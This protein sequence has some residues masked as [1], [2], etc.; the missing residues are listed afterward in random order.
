MSSEPAEPQLLY[1]EAGASWY[2]L[3]AGPAAAISI[4]LVQA[5]SGAH[6]SYAVPL[7]FLV[8]VSFFLGIQVKA[9]RVHTSLELTEDMLRQGTET[10]LIQEIVR[11]FPEAENH[12]K[13]GKPLQKWQDSRT[14]GELSGV[15]RGRYGIGL[16]LVG[17]RTVQ[18]WARH[19]RRLRAAIEPLVIERV[20]AG[21]TESAETIPGGT[22]TSGPDTHTAETSE[23][24]Q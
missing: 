17:G 3:L 20:G 6:V 4:I 5:S 22:G 18:A 8:V 1:R 24:D 15:P 19:H 16:K 21:P 13:S 9:A 10:I 14:L 7:M 23:G 2:W 12:V 11:V